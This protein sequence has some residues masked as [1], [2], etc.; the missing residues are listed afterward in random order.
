VPNMKPSGRAGTLIVVGFLLFFLVLAAAFL[1]ASWVSYDGESVGM[2]SAGYVAM[3]FGIIMTLALGVGLM[4]LVYFSN[5]H[6][7][8]L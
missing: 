4:S 3:T 2:T 6:G 7:R 1:Y 8:D 5:R